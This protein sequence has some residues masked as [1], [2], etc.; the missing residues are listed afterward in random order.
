MPFNDVHAEHVDIA[1]VACD[2]TI[3]REHASIEFKSALTQELFAPCNGF[4]LRVGLEDEQ[5]TP[6]V[7][8]AQSLRDVRVTIV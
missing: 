2:L 1:V 6:A 7:A 8:F 3:A 4:G 5:L